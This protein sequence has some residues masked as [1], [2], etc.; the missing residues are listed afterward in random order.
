MAIK[1]RL[2]AAAILV[3]LVIGGWYWLRPTPI[4]VD[5][6][7]LVVQA[8]P[9]EIIEH[10]KKQAVPLVLVNFWASWC[11]P[12]KVEFPHL[13]E[14]RQKYADRGLRVIFVS[15]DDAND[16]AAAK[17]FLDEQKVDFMTF[18]KG[19]QSL[20][21]VSEIF[22]QWAGAVPVTLLVAPDFKIVESWEGDAT[23]KE[24]EERVEKHLG[25]T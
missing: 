11:I 14:L 19:T 10:V 5:S 12:C 18:Y 2:L 15:V 7:G 6:T 8:T 16:L 4:G 9:T 13:L 25:G 22:P 17:S 20:Q 3:L 1:W 23:Q 21:F 24:F